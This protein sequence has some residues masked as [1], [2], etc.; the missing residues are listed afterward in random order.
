MANETTSTSLQHLLPQIIQEAMFQAQEA[1]IMRQ[2]VK[3]YSLPAGNGKTVKVPV[4]NAVTAADL[5]EGVDLANS[6]VTAGY[7]ELTVAEA[8]I[9]TTVTD[10]A[11]R[12]A[13][14]NV[15]AD[16]GVLFGRAIAEKM[17]KDLI[18]L[19]AALNGGTTIGDGSTALT[20]ADIFK[21]VA[22]L[23]QRGLSTDGMVAVVSVA[24]A[25]DLKS[26][27]TNTFADPAG[28]VGND[29][30]RNGFVGRLAGIPVYE[31]ANCSAEGAVFHRDAL[32][33]AV[34]ADIA[35]ESQRDASMRGTEL[36]AT[37]T[38]G[39]GELNDT[40]GVALDFTSTL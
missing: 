14:S 37:A 33:L 40:Y 28:S 13:A 18:A 6:E 36:V 21:A 10:L 1:S 15:V 4:Y 16:T 27:M 7:A 34:M 25:F 9:M 19:F 23:R 26:V 24:D 12:S 38:Y 30:L 39:V 20:A 29:A 5:T 11:A 31:S 2:L 17:D 32:G 3:N 22:T 8:G 35:V